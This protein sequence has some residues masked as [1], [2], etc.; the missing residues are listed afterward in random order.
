MNGNGYRALAAA[1]RAGRDVIR[2]TWLGEGQLGRAELL[3]N[4]REEGFPCEV[5]TAEGPVLYERFSRGKILLI[6]GGGHVSRPVSMLGKLLG[7]RVLVVDDRP[8]F[9]GAERFPD[10]DKVCCSDF[11]SMLSRYDWEAYPD[12]SVVIVTRGHAADTVCLREAV[13]HDLPYIGMIGSKT[14]N[15]AVFDVLRREGV[16]EE[17]LARVHAPIGLPIGGRTPEEIAVSI[18]AELVQE[19][20]GMER[21]VF[22]E[23]MLDALTGGTSAGGIMATVVRKRGS[24]PRG[25]GARLLVLPDGEILGTVG[26]GL[27]EHQVIETARELLHAPRPLLRHFDMAN[28]EAGKSGLICG[29]SV[30]VLFEVVE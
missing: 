3:E 1:L 16:T 9:A 14:K 17:Q 7:Y 2:K 4:A 6:C 19:R 15:A 28:G 20:C 25:V 18:A 27:A 23:A 21:A 11:V 10:A 29:G 12:T 13:R 5:E 30:D 22:S 26:G 8:E 24:A